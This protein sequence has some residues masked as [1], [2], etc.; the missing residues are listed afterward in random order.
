VKPRQNKLMS[1]LSKAHHLLVLCEK[2]ALVLLLAS[3]IL[4]SF[5]QVITRNFFSFGFIWAGDFL[6]TEVIWVTFIGA[7]VATEYRKHIRIDIFSRLIRSKN[8]NRIFDLLADLFTTG[9]SA[10]LFVAAVQY[11]ALMKPYFTD[12]LFFGVKEWMIRLVIPY[13]FAAMTIRCAVFV[14]KFPLK[15]NNPAGIQPV[16]GE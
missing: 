7:A 4:L 9:V 12:V 1:W 6:R 13:A 10:L 8:A 2:T 14:V 5:S 15:K 11:I 3:M 16:S